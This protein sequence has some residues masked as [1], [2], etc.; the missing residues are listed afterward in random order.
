MTVEERDLV[1]INSEH[2][3]RAEEVIVHVPLTLT[4]E[5]LDFLEVG[6]GGQIVTV[7]SRKE[8]LRGVNRALAED[9]LHT[10]KAIVLIRCLPGRLPCL[11]LMDGV[12]E[13][14]EAVLVESQERFG[15]HLRLFGVRFHGQ[16]Q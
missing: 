7:D 8:D 9:S 13:T 6:F 10:A 16:E 15:P 4:E 2:L 3:L 5:I 11:Q 14:P 1:T 12:T